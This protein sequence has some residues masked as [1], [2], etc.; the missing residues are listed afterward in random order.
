MTLIPS[1][2]ATST[3]LGILN[4]IGPYGNVSTSTAP[5]ANLALLIS[6][7]IGFLTL[8]AGIYFL[9]RIITTGFKWITGGHDKQ[10]IQD[11]QKQM[12]NGFIG[13]LIVL[14]AYFFAQIISYVF[15]INF[16]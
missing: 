8:V 3:N 5:F 7:L 4:G 13:L 16:L 12:L 14:S 1:A 10:A 15:G 2:H 9:F 11:A 6:N